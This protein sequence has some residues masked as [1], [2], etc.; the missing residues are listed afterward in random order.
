M[1]LMIQVI[2][3]M[4]NELEYSDFEIDEIFNNIK[5]GKISFQDLLNVLE[6]ETNPT[7]IQSAQD[8]ISRWESA[9]LAATGRRLG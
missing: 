8:K 9:F 2:R 3:Y 6:L 4:I 1:L 5:T 7:L